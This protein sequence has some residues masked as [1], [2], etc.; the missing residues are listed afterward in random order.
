MFVEKVSISINLNNYEF[1]LIYI[2]DN[3]FY[4]TSHNGNMEQDFL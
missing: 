3:A 2:S 1:G 4:V